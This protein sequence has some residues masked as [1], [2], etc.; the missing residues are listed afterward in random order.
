MKSQAHRKFAGFTLMEL[1]IAMV[2]TLILLYAA[3]MAFRDA[4]QSN[5]V[6]TQA[7][8]PGP[9]QTSGDERVDFPSLELLRIRTAKITGAG[10]FRTNGTFHQNRSRNFHS[11]VDPTIS[12]QIC[13]GVPQLSH[14]L[15]SAVHLFDLQLDLQ[16]TMV[17]LN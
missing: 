12:L 9:V 10:P 14:D 4:S 7:A 15:T 17:C 1:M 13:E 2:V 3:V 6:V 5:T 16:L 8:Q 11:A